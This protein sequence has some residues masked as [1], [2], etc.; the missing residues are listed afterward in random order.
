MCVT[1]A[2]LFVHHAPI[3]VMPYSADDVWDLTKEGVPMVGN[4]ITLNCIV[5]KQYVLNS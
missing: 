2:R 3:N 1:V 5:I 4:L